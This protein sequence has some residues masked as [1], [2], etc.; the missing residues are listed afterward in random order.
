MLIVIQSTYSVCALS[1]IFKKHLITQEWKELHKYLKFGSLTV[2][3]DPLKIFF[4]GLVI[5]NES[6]PY[7]FL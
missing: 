4:D 7:A 3:L 6:S 1:W 5:V 2:L